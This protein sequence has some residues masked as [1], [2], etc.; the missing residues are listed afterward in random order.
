MVYVVLEKEARASDT[1]STELQLS[2]FWGNLISE[3]T[4]NQSMSTP[5]P[6]LGQSLYRSFFTELGGMAVPQMLS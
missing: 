4:H 1:S 5:V 6:S 2:Y 3:V